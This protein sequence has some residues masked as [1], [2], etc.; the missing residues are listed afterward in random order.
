MGW[1]R[2]ALI[3]PLCLLLAGCGGQQAVTGAGEEDVSEET[4]R[5]GLSRESGETGGRE[6]ALGSSGQGVQEDH[7]VQLA[8]DPEGLGGDDG[9]D[10]REEE[11]NMNTDYAA[12]FE[13]MV[14]A[15]A[16]KGLEDANPLMTQRFGADP[17]AMEYDG[18][19]YFYMTAD[20]FEY[21]GGEVM[22]NTYGRIRQIN[23]ISTADMVNFT[24]HGSI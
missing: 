4:G 20:A 12:Y 5:Q 2:G 22:E 10:N 15:E 6:A 9:E 8:G 7:R 17:Y 11:G 14:T 21:Q 24:D 3:L 19:V 23:V 16:Y 18:R 1:K 13:D